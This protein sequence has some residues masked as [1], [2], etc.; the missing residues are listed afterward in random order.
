MTIDAGPDELFTT[1]ASAAD[2][3]GLVELVNAAY[4]GAASR[5]GWTSEAD[6][7]TG[8]RIDAAALA[9]II[10]ASDAAV[11]VM[12]G[13]PGLFACVHVRRVSAER[14]AVGLLTVRPAL[15]G[16]GIGRRLLA[17]AEAYARASLG[18]RVVELTVLT[19]REELLAWCERRGY[20]LTGETRPLPH[21]ERFGVPVRGDLALA[22]L[23]R[24]IA[25]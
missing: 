3:A 25:A 1:L 12:R 18:A 5:R 6:L 17:A 14:A 15:Q 16:N 8:A 20:H 10:G 23:E 21:D 19:A 2:V 7:L 9:E 22:V 13:R 11:L 24:Q 4:R